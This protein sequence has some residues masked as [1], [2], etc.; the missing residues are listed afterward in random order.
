[1][2]IS[3]RKSLRLRRAPGFRN[4]PQMT[5]MTQIHASPPH[6]RSGISSDL[7]HLR[8]SLASLQNSDLGEEVVAAS[9]RA[10]IPK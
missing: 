10:G 4:D 8:M 2:L 6:E 1:M 7:R 5:P 9:P 3:A